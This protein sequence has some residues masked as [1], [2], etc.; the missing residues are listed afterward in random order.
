MYSTNI[1]AQI[2]IVN[3]G[4]IKKSWKHNNLHEIQT[5]SLII[6]CLFQGV[7]VTA[8]KQEPIEHIE[9]PIIEGKRKRTKTETSTET[10]I[11][12]VFWKRKGYLGFNLVKLKKPIN[13]II[14]KNKQK[15][16]W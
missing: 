14:V 11:Y 2:R 15:Q 12:L 7:A 1:F 8:V 10:V 5:E 16:V 9:T 4:D 3:W 13:K 6:V